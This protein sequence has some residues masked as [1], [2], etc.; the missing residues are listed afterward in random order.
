MQEVNETNARDVFDRLDAI[1]PDIALRLKLTLMQI[2][3]FGLTIYILIGRALRIYN[4]FP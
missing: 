3:G 4:D 1:I 2:S